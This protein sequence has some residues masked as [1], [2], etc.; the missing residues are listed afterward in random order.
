LKRLLP[1]IVIAPVFATLVACGGGGTTP[2]ST[3]TGPTELVLEDL[4]VGTGATAVNGDS[5]S[6]YYVGS[7]LNGQVFDSNV[8]GSALVFTLGAG[9]VIPGFEQG[10][11]GMKV[12]GRRR[13][14]IPAS[15]AY[16][17]Q[18]RGPIPPNTPLRFD[19]ELA[20]IAGK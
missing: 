3:P 5:V 13:M 7:F 12:G 16:G 14:T 11:V 17:S 19:V 9:Q 10:I 4:V 18:G 1:L 8:G 20:A 2:S 6:V 15:L